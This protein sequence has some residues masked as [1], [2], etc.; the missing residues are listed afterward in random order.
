MCF[1]AVEK[2]PEEQPV[3]P[4]SGFGLMISVLVVSAAAV[5]PVH[6]QICYWSRHLEASIP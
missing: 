5:E 2:G 3:L 4:D 1:P 6:C